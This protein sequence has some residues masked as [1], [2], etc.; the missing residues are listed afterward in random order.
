MPLFQ[1]NLHL[2]CVLKSRPFVWT[3]TRA[4]VPIF[5]PLSLGCR[6]RCVDPPGSGLRPMLPL[7]LELSEQNTERH[8]R[9]GTAPG[10]TA[11]GTPL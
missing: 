8:F 5:G 7:D 6:S 2:A 1:E 9:P 11:L 3:V 4:Q 10:N